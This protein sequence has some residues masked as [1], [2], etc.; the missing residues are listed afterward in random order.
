M[1][2]DNKYGRVT[3]ERGDIGEDE[4]VVVFRARDVL[5][6]DVLAFYLH[7]CWQLQSPEKHLALIC[8]SQNQ[9]HYWQIDHAEEV[10]VPTSRNYNPPKD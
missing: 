10:R 5:L 8:R 7:K 1:A 6:P 3:L 2:I 9:V 4:P